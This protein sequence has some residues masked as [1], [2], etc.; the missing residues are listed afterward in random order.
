M[1]RS[2]N[3]IQAFHITITNWEGKDKIEQDQENAKKE[4]IR[5]SGEGAGGFIEEMYS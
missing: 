1:K 3:Y 5:K 2:I 4:L